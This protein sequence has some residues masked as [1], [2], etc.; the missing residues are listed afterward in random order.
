MLT[1]VLQLLYGGGQNK[2]L[3]Q[4]RTSRHVPGRHR[5]RELRLEA[6]LVKQLE[7]HACTPIIISTSKILVEVRLDEAMCSGKISQLLAGFACAAR[8]CSARLDIATPSNWQ[9]IN[10]R[11]PLLHMRVMPAR[12]PCRQQGA[13]VQGRGCQ[14]STLVAPFTLRG[15]NVN[16][17]WRC[18]VAGMP[19]PMADGITGRATKD[20][21]M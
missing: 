10:C 15:M 9:A 21:K 20:V 6:D 12:H 17:R 8:S 7:Q 2:R 13:H 19:G 5:W 3:A 16:E 18:C 14:A 1:Y 11:K 4:N